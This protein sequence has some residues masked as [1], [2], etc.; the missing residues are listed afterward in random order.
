[1]HGRFVAAYMPPQLRYADLHHLTHSE[2]ITTDKEMDCDCNLNRAGYSRSDRAM[3]YVLETPQEVTTRQATATARQGLAESRARWG[4][5]LS[6]DP[7]EMDHDLFSI[8]WDWS[9]G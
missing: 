9:G 1:M 4:R 6:H 7:H 3:D 8:P 5:I 2:F